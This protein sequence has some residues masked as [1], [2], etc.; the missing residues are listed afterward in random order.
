VP[1][2]DLATAAPQIFWLAVVFALM[3]LVVSRTLPRVAAVQET[4]ATTIAS[5]LS[6]ASQARDA[7]RAASTGASGA[8]NTAREAALRTVGEA[9]DRAGARTG[10]RL[11]AVDRELDAKASAAEAALAVTRDRALADLDRIAA[12]AAADLVQRLAGVPVSVEEAAQAVRRA[13]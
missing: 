11:R 6:A 5:E 2:F 3:F 13:A 7:A 1:Q 4:R 12:E 9:K 8:L 10:E